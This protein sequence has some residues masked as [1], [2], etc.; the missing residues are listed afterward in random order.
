M[1][2]QE[3]KT[4][5]A[6]SLVNQYDSYRPAIIEGLLREGETMNVIAA[7]KTGKSWLVL[8]MSFSIA[9]GSSFLGMQCAKGPVLIVDNELHPQTIS[10]RLNVVA[11]EMGVTFD[12]V[13][14]LSLRG[15]LQDLAVL[16]PMIIEEAQKIGASVIVL[17]AL[18]RLIPEGTSE[19][20]NAGMMRIYNDLDR[21]AATSKAAI[22]CIHHSSKG[23]QG[24]KSITDGGSGAGAISRAADSHIFLREHENDGCVTFD[25]VAR[26]WPP[27]KSKVLRR[28]GHLREVDEEGNPALTKGRKILKRQSLPPED[29]LPFIPEKPRKKNLF[30]E[31]I[32]SK[33]GSTRSAVCAALATL[34]GQNQ[35]IIYSG[36]NRTQFVAPANWKEA[37]EATNLQRAADYIMANPEVSNYLVAT[38]LSIDPS[39]VSR[40]RQKA[41]K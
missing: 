12:G 32:A 3:T 39:T 21:I 14:V 8:Q 11:T 37:T 6:L 40:A 16:S 10:M 26:S 1:K 29:L 5:S 23:N 18:Y 31:E 13:H 19:N 22:V 7:P 28:V 33:L 41:I 4:I 20:D 34:E 24:E 2:T 35:C 36:A 17:D 27:P 15:K 38:A 9:N 25:A 30:A